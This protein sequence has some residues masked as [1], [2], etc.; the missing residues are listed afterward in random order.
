MRRSDKTGVAEFVHDRV[1]S[2]VF[3]VCPFVRSPRF[4]ISFQPNV[5]VKE[6]VSRNFKIIGVTFQSF[7]AWDGDE[8]C[9]GTPQE[10]GNP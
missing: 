10:M 8:W 2:L 1:A 5:E 3:V 9:Y 7:E 4:I 6:L